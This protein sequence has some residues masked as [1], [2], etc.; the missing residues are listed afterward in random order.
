M[1]VPLWQD[2]QDLVLSHQVAA[3]AQVRSLAW[4]I[5]LVESAI[6][7]QTNKQKAIT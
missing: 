7:K 6:K 5:P 4:E 2:L 1:G 3:V